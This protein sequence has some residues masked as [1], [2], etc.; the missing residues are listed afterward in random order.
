M[1]EILNKSKIKLLK[2]Y[3]VPVVKIN[4]YAFNA[5]EWDIKYRSAENLAEIATMDYSII[6]K[7][8][9]VVHLQKL[10]KIRI[11]RIKKEKPKGWEAAHKSMTTSLEQITN[12]LAMRKMYGNDWNNRKKK[13]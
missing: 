11:K 6:E 5:F 12:E 3:S 4:N 8:D 2:S 13:K 1:Y 9:Q 10:L 7:R